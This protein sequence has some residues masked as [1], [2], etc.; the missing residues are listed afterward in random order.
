MFSM[1]NFTSSA[2]ISSPLW[3]FTPSRSLN[4]QVVSLIIFQLSARS[5]LREKSSSVPTSVS[6]MMIFS[7][8]AFRCRCPD[9][10]RASTIRWF[11]TINTFS[12]ALL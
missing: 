10:L 7:V 1:E 6:V 11:P 8:I 4:S 2:V 12:S 9:Q 3:N 5:G